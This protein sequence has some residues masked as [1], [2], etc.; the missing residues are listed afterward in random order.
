M[1][2]L[3]TEEEQILKMSARDF[4]EGE[5]PPDL[6]RAMETD[7]LGYPPELWQKM[8]EL[9]WLG[10]AIPQEYGGQGLPLAYLGIFMEELGRAIAP[11]PFHSTMTAAL[12]IAQDGTEQ[13]RRE[14]LPRVARGDLV[15]TW[16]LT[17]QDP[18]LLPE[19]IRT[20]ATPDG[21]GYVITGTKMFVENFRAAGTCLVVCRTAEASDAGEGIS[22]FLV[23]TRSPGITETPLITIAKDK[24]SKVE[25][26]QVRVPQENLV[27][28]LHQGWP[29]V[30]RMVERA[31]ALLCTQLLGAA[32]KQAEMAIDYAK[33]RVA[34]GRPIGAFQSIGHLCA[35]MIISVDGGQLLTYEA[36]WRL[37]QG[38]PASIEVS[39]AK[40]FCNDKCIWVAWGSNQIHGGIGFIQEFNLNLWFRRIAGMAMRLGTSTEHRARVAG[41][42]LDR[43]GHVRLGEDMYRLQPAAVAA[44]R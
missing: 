7:A 44:I 39:Q 25:F 17:E 20:R 34:F 14:I 35:D 6:V 4:F 41:E 32:R 36:L 5:C 37:D 12:T 43:P 21:D 28:E 16:A 1:D 11:V 9:D 13:Q 27:G 26:Q 15:L 8:A 22:L 38:L 19:T 3:L 23:D 31:T 24:Q 18:R 2:V 30:Q 29:V 42:L 33:H 40:A 10:L